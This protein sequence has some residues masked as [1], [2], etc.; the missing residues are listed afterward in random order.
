VCCTPLVTF[1]SGYFLINSLIDCTCYVP[2]CIWY[3][4]RDCTGCGGRLSSATDGQIT[5]PGWPNAY[6]SSSNC[7]WVIAASRPGL[8]NTTI[9]FFYIL[10]VGLHLRGRFLFK[11]SGAF[12]CVGCHCVIPYGSWHSVTLRWVCVGYLLLDCR[13]HAVAPNCLYRQPVLKLWKKV[14]ELWQTSEAP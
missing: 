1:V 11:I 9:D 10:L 13:L 12:I 3:W 4:R 2:P 14:E 7:T 8:Q 5:S 6:S